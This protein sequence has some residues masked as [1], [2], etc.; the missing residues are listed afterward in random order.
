MHFHLQADARANGQA[1]ARAGEGDGRSERASTAS[2]TREKVNLRLEWQVGGMAGR[3][4]R[5]VILD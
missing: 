4:H 3:G 1:G 5:R 2:G